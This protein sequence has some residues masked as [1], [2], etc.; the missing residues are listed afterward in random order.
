MATLRTNGQSIGIWGEEPFQLHTLAK[1]TNPLTASLECFEHDTISLLRNEVEIGSR[2]Q[3]ESNETKV[4]V[5][6][7]DQW[8]EEVTSIIFC[9]IIFC[10]QP[11][12]LQRTPKGP[13]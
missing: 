4:K 2:S 7:V 9:V 12:V 1:V 10:V 6:F 11:Y 3:D 13:K 5:D 8:L